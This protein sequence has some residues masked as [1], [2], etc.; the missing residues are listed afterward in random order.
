M[1]TIK[2]RRPWAVLSA[3]AATLGFVLLSAGCGSGGGTQNAALAPLSDVTATTNP[4]TRATENT[5]SD[6][7]KTLASRQASGSLVSLDAARAFDTD[8]SAIRAA[9]PDLQALHAKTV[10]NTKKI[11]VYAVYT[12]FFVEKWFDA[13]VKEKQNPSLRSRFDDGE[14]RFR[15]PHQKIRC[16]RN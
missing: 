2:L 1:K 13:S 11:V 3:V 6:D 15:R 10:Y 16:R 4:I 5:V 14:T 9:Y 12:A 7:A 8:L